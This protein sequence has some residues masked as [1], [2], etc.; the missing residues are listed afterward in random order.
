M[1]QFRENEIRKIREEE[2][3]K[4]QIELQSLRKEV[5][6]KSS[7]FFKRRKKND[8]FHFQLEMLHKSKI[9]SLNEKELRIG[10]RFKSELEVKIRKKFFEKIFIGRIQN[11]RRELFLQRQAFLEELKTMKLR[12]TENQRSLDLRER[13]VFVWKKFYF[14]HRW[15]NLFSVRWH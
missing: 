10:D 6:E 7:L 5:K 8:D 15:V 4:C 9:E 2:R 14:D 13:S 1:E 11:E 3:Q 12:E